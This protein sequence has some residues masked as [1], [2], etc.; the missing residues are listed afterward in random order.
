[1]KSTASVFGLVFLVVSGII[2]LGGI[3]CWIIGSQMPNYYQSDIL[4]SVPLWPQSDPYDS[5]WL[6]RPRDSHEIPPANLTISVPLITA[7][8]KRLTAETSAHLIHNLFGYDIDL[9]LLRHGQ[10]YAFSVKR[11]AAVGVFDT[12]E[13]DRVTSRSL[14]DTLKIGRFFRVSCPYS[15]VVTVNA[16]VEPQCQRAIGSFVE[17]AD[18]Y[19][20]I[21]LPGGLPS[22]ATEFSIVFVRLA[23]VLTNYVEDPQLY[24]GV[25]KRSDTDSL[26]V[27]GAILTGAGI[28]ASLVTICIFFAYSS[29]GT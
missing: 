26:M 29:A 15:T 4:I 23:A 1:M 9:R 20:V 3:P 21:D 28:L 10:S 22:N 6:G 27:G 17:L 2:L 7:D 11:N 12:E 5:L 16:N 24:I 8:S 19:E 25:W 14:P 13:I 18:K